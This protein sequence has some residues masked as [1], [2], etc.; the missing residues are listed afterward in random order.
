MPDLK[1][2]NQWTKKGLYDLA[3]QPLPTMYYSC[4]IGINEAEKEAW[5][6][7]KNE[8][9]NPEINYWH[10]VPALRLLVDINKS[11]FRMFGDGPAFMEVN[12]LTGELERIKKNI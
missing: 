2:I 9:N 1:E 7:Y 12:R 3:K 11:K 8:D 10:K 6:L 5:K 4:I